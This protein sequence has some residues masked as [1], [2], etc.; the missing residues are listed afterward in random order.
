MTTFQRLFTEHPA[1][2]NETYLQHL[3]SAMGFGIAMVLSGIACMI[4]GLLPAAFVTRGSDTIR[5][6]HDRMITN[7]CR[8]AP[9]E[10]AARPPVTR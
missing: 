10:V 9:R 8:V 4:H 5:E 1:S 2:V 7:R 6:L 3:R